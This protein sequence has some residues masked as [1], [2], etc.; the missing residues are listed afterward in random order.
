[1]PRQPIRKIRGLSTNSAVPSPEAAVVSRNFLHNKPGTAESRLGSKRIWDTRT[2]NAVTQAI[3]EWRN[4]SGTVFRMTKCNGAL[5]TF[6]LTASTAKTSL[7]TGMS[8]AGVA[9]MRALDGLLYVADQQNENKISTGSSGADNTQKLRRA[10]PSTA[11]SPTEGGVATGFANGVYK[12]CYTHYNASLADES[13]PRAVESVTKSNTAQGIQI[14]IPSNPGSGYS[15]RIYRTLVGELGPLYRVATST[16]YGGTDTLTVSDTDIDAAPATYP[17]STLHNNDGEI[18]AAVP[19][20]CFFVESNKDVLWLGNSASNPLRVFAAKIGEPSNFSVTSLAA[21]PAKHHDLLSGQGQRIMGMND[22]NGSLVVFKDF[23]IHVKNGGSDSFSW[24]WYVPVDG[25]GCI[26]Q[27]TR[28][29]APGIGIFFCSANGI[30]L[31]DGARAHNLSDK[32]DGRGIGDDYRALDRTLTAKWV[33]AWDEANRC[34]LVAVTQSGDTNPTRVYAYFYDTGEWGMFEFG[35]GNIAITS[36]GVITNSSSVPTVVLGSSDGYAY[37]LNYAT[38]TDGPISGT[39]T[40]TVTSVTGN[41]LNDSGAS[42][43]TT[44]DGLIGLVVTVRMSAT[45]Y[46]S[47]VITGTTGTQIQVG[48]AWTGAPTG[49]TYFVGAIRN[50]LALGGFDA[51][52]AGEKQWHAINI[53]HAKQTHTVP[54]RIGFTLND[55]TVPTYTGDENTMVDVRGSVGVN[56]YAVEC[57]IYVDVIGTSSPIEIKGVEYDLS[58]CKTR[59]PAA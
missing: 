13:P 1:M 24:E 26:A 3:Y 19:D 50:T 10:A 29:V 28:A 41:H 31:F 57:G 36:M 27:W 21:S 18:T 34:Y 12:V 5:E 53:Q 52:D 25:T 49:K 20:A 7:E 48:S 40:G 14:T 35:M 51:G 9:D 22:L 45:S 42:F 4:N 46:E 38:Q 11:L 6:S 37:F 43:Y 16:N 54:V 58:Y 17:I 44:N 32:P 47:K 55:D 33:G 2:A 39:V 15:F 30:Y 8:T 59:S 23:C 56:D